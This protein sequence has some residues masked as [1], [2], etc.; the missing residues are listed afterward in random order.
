MGTY[1]SELHPIIE[2]IIGHRYG[3][4]LNVGCSF[5]YYSVGLAS[6]LA[7]SVIVAAD[8]DHKMI[9]LC[10]YNASMNGCMNVV[11][12]ELFNFDT[13]FILMD[14]EGGEEKYLDPLLHDF[15]KIDILV[16]LH[17][18]DYPGIANR[19]INKFKG[20]H[21]IELIYNDPCYFDLQE[22]F[23]LG[24]AFEH[25]DDAIVTYEGRAG[26]TPWAWMKHK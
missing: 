17:E 7:G 2:E 16:E 13:D 6:R 4:I 10:L 26:Q 12:G 1:E 9:D 22:V 19:I 15:S 3:S 8:T 21:Y 25:F 11:S 20:R 24:C 18:C 14:C 23:G 5:G